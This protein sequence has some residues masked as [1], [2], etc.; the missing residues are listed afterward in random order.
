MDLPKPQKTSLFSKIKVKKVQI[1]DKFNKKYQN[2][3]ETR[4]FFGMLF[5]II[6]FGT[7]GF[8]TYIALISPSLILKLAFT[9]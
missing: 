4:S 3:D 6:L 7:L 2:S 9:V 1:K 8:V 5:D